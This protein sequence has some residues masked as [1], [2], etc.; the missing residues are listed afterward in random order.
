MSDV[1]PLAAHTELLA[2]QF[3]HRDRGIFLNSAAQGI[4]ARRTIEAM[5]EFESDR[6]Y[7]PAI[8]DPRLL[9]VETTCRARVGRLLGAPPELVGLGVNTSEGIN[10]AALHLPLEA[11]QRVLVARG[12]FPANVYPWLG[13]ARKGVETVFLEL[14]G[15]HLSPERV[16][17]AL[18]ADPAI[19]VVSMSLVQF[20]NGHRNPVEAVGR[21]CREHGVSFVVDAIQGLGAVPLDWS[22][23][24]ADLLACGGQK[25]L[26]GPWGS[27]FF[28]AAEWLCAE[29]EP[30]RIGWLQVSGAR[31]YGSLCDYDLRFERDARRF[32]VGTYPYTALLGLSESLDLVHTLGIERIAGHARTMIQRLEE[33]LLELGAT[34]VSCREPA[35]RSSILCFR[36]GDIADTRAIF[37]GLRSAGVVCAFREGSIRLSPHYYNTMDEIERTLEAVESLRPAAA[38][39]R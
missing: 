24:G 33:G 7:P 17:E 39:G 28:V 12:E 30:V 10:V 8:D 35:C 37:D 22:E 15:P 6:A 29:I 14:D 20:S 18:D 1:S 31:D 32:E 34:I 2:S 26:C 13:L 25:W 9:E 38:R 3:P 27:G 36:A 21:V 11:G 5:H 16:A 23:T 19:R 4:L